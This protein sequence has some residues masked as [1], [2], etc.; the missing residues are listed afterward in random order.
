M[1]KE[2]K[3]KHEFEG[4]LALCSIRFHT[5]EIWNHNITVNV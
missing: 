5:I 1:A 2:Q 4:N 3:R